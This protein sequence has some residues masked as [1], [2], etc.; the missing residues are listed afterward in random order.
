[1]LPLIRNCVLFCAGPVRACHTLLTFGFASGSANKV[2][3]QPRPPSRAGVA[4]HRR[5]GE[6]PKECVDRLNAGVQMTRQCDCF[7][8]L[9]A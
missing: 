2:D 8:A 4:R 1:M 5:L 7:G 9:N 6:Q 3:R